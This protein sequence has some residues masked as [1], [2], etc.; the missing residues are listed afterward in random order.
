MQNTVPKLILAKAYALYFHP[1]NET[2]LLLESLASPSDSEIL[3]TFVVPTGANARE[4]VIDLFADVNGGRF[5]RASGSPPVRFG[6][7]KS[8]SAARSRQPMSTRS[9]ERGKRRTDY[10]LKSG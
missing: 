7:R 2:S 6:E 1:E 9:P 4:R 8:E 10:R 5:T 3:V